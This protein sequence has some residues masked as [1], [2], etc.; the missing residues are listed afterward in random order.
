MDFSATPAQDDLGA[1]VRQILTDRVTPERLREV[2]ARLQYIEGEN[3]MPADDITVKDDSFCSVQFDNK[4]GKVKLVPAKLPMQLRKPQKED[5]A[6]K[7]PS[8]T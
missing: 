3:A 7:D 4:T 1:L 8:K 2:E 6:K 5:P